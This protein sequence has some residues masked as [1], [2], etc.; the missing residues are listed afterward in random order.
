MEYSLLQQALRSA[1]IDRKIYYVFRVIIYLY[2]VFRVII[3]L[4]NF[5]LTN[6]HDI[7]FHKSFA[8][9]LLHLKID[10]E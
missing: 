10:L 9:R 8:E 6:F 5:K 4:S 1:T 2:Y 3:Y 7:V